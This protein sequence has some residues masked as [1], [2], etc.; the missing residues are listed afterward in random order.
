MQDDA[1]VKKEVPTNEEFKREHTGPNTKITVGVHQQ[2]LE[3]QKGQP[4]KGAIGESNALKSKTIKSSLEKSCD[5]TDCT[6][7]AQ[8]K[9]PTLP[10]DTDGEMSRMLCSL[11]QQTFAGDPLEYHFFM[12]SFTEAV[13]RKV[14]DLHGRLVQLLKFTDGEAKE[15]IR[16]CIQ[17]PSEIGYRLAKSLLEDHYGNPRHILAAYRKEIK[18]WTPLKP[19]TQQHIGSSTIF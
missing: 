9:S 16:H 5:R 18:S 17:Q 2:I 6:A 1:F 19:G 8:A 11:F 7:D 15:T 10:K 3:Q 13:E 14:D 12:S 4:S